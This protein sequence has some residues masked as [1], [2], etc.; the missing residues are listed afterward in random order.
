MFKK[1]TC[2]MCTASL[3]V[4]RTIWTRRVLTLHVSLTKD[5]RLLETN[6]EWVQCPEYHKSKAG[7]F[8]VNIWRPKINIKAIKAYLEATQGQGL[9]LRTPSLLSMMSPQSLL[10]ANTGLVSAVLQAIWMSLSA[11]HD[12]IMLPKQT[13]A[14]DHKLQIKTF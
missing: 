5:S 12:S 10:Y 4:I 7:Q 3:V 14:S 13:A 6:Q 11:V 2:L 1:Y 8:N 9:A